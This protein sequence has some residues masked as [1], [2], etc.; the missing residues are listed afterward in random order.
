VGSMGPPSGRATSRSR[1]ERTLSA[2]HPRRG[3]LKKEPSRRLG[4]FRSNM[5]RTVSMLFEKG[6]RALASAA[7]RGRPQWFAGWGQAIGQ[8][9]SAGGPGGRPPTTAPGGPG[10]SGKKI[11]GA[12]RYALGKLASQRADGF[13]HC[14]RA[15]PHGWHATR[16]FAGVRGVARSPKPPRT[17]ERRAP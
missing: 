1:Q 3:C 14:V 4:R 16:F 13:P 15:R 11:A 10:P 12:Q 7:A 2:F 8:T 6:R 17:Y 5:G 9:V